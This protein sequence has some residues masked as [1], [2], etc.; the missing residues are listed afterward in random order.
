[1]P[2]TTDAADPDDRVAADRVDRV[3]LGRDG[4]ES[5]SDVYERSRPGYAE[6]AV[7]ALVDLA[8]IGPGSRVL[9]VAAGTGKLTRCLPP[10]GAACVAVEPSASMREVFAGVVP[11]VPVMGGTVEE[12][13]LADGSVDAV[14]VAQ[15]FHWFDAPQA[16]AEIARVLRP[17]GSLSLVWNERDDSDPVMAEL[18]RISR[19]DRHQPYPV[20]MDFSPRVDASGRFGPVTRTQG[21]FVQ[22]VDRTAFVEQVAS[23]SYVRLLGEA[24]R[25]RLLD[26]VGAFG[27]TLAEPIELPYR[28]DLFTA[29]RLG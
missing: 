15:A 1:M 12:L 29:T 24:E 10:F 4:F 17:G 20:G 27:A 6:E 3:R 8:G 28:Y 5:A 22:I 26:E 25:S 2:A 7:A 16:L 21:S 14:V 11:G 13:P 18:V 19:W 23:R 9:D